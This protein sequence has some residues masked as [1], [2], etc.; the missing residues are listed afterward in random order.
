MENGSSKK[1]W[2]FRGSEVVIMASKISIRGTLMMVKENLNEA[3]TR[4]TIPLGHGDPSAFP[5][6]RTAASAEDAVADALRSAKFN[7]YTP[8]LGHL[9]AKR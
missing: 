4:P 2:G 1:K 5:C 7:S 8:T 3:D 9:P 6:F